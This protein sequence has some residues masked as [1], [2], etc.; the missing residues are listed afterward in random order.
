MKKEKKEKKR[1]RMSVAET[2]MFRWTRSKTRKDGIRKNI[3]DKQGGV[4]ITEDKTREK[5]GDQNMP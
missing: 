3:R 5:Y 4:T 1:D 2:R